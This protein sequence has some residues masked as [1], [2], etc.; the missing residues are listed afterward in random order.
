MLRDTHGDLYDLA[1]W[2][3]MQRRVR[4]GEIV[5]IFPYDASLRLH[6]DET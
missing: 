2:L 1:F 4:S 6:L 3:E 5:D